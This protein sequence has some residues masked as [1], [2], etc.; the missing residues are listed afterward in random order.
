MEMTLLGVRHS[1]LRH[2]IGLTLLI[3]V[4]ASMDRAE[5]A[6][7]PASPVDNVTVTCTGTT[8]NQNGVNG[9]GSGGDATPRDNG[10]TYNIVSGASLTGTRNGLLVGRALI[11]NNFGT[12]TGG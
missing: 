9:Y 6:C 3:A 4:V 2:A 5:A 8:T 10:N 1:K 11:I 7:D 12:I